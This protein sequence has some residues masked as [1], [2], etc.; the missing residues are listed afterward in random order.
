MKSEK[1]K[2]NELG[3]ENIRREWTARHESFGARRASTAAKNKHC[4][5]G[6]W[7]WV[8]KLEEV[9]QQPPLKRARPRSCPR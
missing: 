6:P 5:C 3:A 4:L 9:D 7:S 2:W 1:R 8:V